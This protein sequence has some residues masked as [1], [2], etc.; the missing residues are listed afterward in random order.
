M[1]DFLNKRVKVSD[2]AT[3][4]GAN[5]PVVFTTT[6]DKFIIT[7]GTPI[8][9]QRWGVI[10]TTAKDA[11]AFVA[12][13]ALRPTAGSDTN[14]AV[15]DTLTD[16]A[17]ARAAGVSLERRIS[18]T[19]PNSSTGSD[20]SLVNVAALATGVYGE[21][22]TVLPGQEAVFAVTT[23]ASATGGG[24]IYAE[25]IEYPSVPEYATLQST[26]LNYTV[27]QL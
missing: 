13:L 14:R 1:H 3:P 7:P 12:T 24:Y 2:Y 20:G 23:G 6:G 21:G 9:I 8:A 22:V 19:N 4:T 18:G 25:Y 16:S 27:V 17:T 11:S 15:Q 10:I 26:T 5:G